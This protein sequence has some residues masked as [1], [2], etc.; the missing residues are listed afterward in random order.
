MVT[1]YAS[2]PSLSNRRHQRLLIQSVDCMIFPNSSFDGELFFFIASTLR[3]QYKNKHTNL[4]D[5][6]VSY[7]GR[8]KN[9]VM[10]ILGLDCNILNWF[11]WIVWKLSPLPIMVDGCFPVK[12]PCCVKHRDASAHTVSH[13]CGVCFYMSAAFSRA[14]AKDKKA[15]LIGVLA[16]ASSSGW[17]LCLF[18]KYLLKAVM[19]TELCRTKIHSHILVCW[20][21]SD[22]WPSFLHWSAFFSSFFSVAELLSSC[23]TAFPSLL[24]CR[25]VQNKIPHLSVICCRLGEVR[26]LVD[27]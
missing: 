23:W 8:E 18:N 16:A 14:K 6:L 10:I 11:E 17:N 3:N 2:S 5:V 4:L 22:F 13:T 24:A 26:V 7:G 20:K 1:L 27:R 21:S 19:Q 25:S 12:W 9:T 15:S